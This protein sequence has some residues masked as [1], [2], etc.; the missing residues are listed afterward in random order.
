MKKTLV[1][2]ILALTMAAGLAFGAQAEEEVIKIGFLTPMSGDT[3][4]YGYKKIR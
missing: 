1:T 2:S 3:A 4:T